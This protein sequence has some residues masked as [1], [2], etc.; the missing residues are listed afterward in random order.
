MHQSDSQEVTCL[1][2]IGPHMLAAIP[3]IPMKTFHHDLIGV[4]LLLAPL[5]EHHKPRTWTQRVDPAIPNR[6]DPQSSTATRTDRT[7]VC[8]LEPA[9]TES[10]TSI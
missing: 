3:R 8:N 1:Y 2:L 6:S 5:S 10:A 7:S 4:Q 9:F